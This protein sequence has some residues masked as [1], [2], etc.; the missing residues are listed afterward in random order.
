[1]HSNII[2]IHSYYFWKVEQQYNQVIV[3]EMADSDLAKEI[4]QRSISKKSFEESAL[5]RIFNELIDCL[6]YLMYN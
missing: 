1:M 5:I 2:K 6:A 4:L 3:M